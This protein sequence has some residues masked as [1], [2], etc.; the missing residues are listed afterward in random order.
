[1]ENNELEACDLGTH[2]YWEERYQEEIINFRN[3]GD[4]GDIW[5]GED[6]LERLLRW[7]D[8]CSLISKTSAISDIG[9]GNGIL[10]IELSKRGFENLLGVDYSESAIDLAKEI[11]KNSS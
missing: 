11:A 6:I 4:V 1:M 10:L 2:E 9:C 5:F 7:I 8:K 3:H